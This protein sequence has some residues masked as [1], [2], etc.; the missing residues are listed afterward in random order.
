MVAQLP[1]DGVVADVRVLR[2]T[3]RTL[4]CRYA[5][6]NAL[7]LVIR[8][9]LTLDLVHTFSIVLLTSCL[10]ASIGEA[11]VLRLGISEI[12]H[13]RTSQTVLSLVGE[14][15]PVLA[16]IRSL[17]EI[18]IELCSVFKLSPDALDALLLAQVDLDPGWSGGARAPECAVV[19]INRIFRTEVV[20]VI[21]RGCNLGAECEVLC[22]LHFR[23]QIETFVGWNDLLDGTVCIEFEFI[24]C[25]LTMESTV[26]MRI[27]MAMIY[28][29]VV[30][31]FLE[32]AV[33]SRTMNGSIGIG[34]EDSSVVGVRTERTLGCRRRCA[35]AR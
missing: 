24:D 33:V 21:G 18:L 20:V 22:H 10:S 23:F 7:L 17:D 25:H 6:C 11:D 15:L 31:A 16:V 12:Y 27:V 2:V 13:R 30:V 29:V 3:V 5:R 32:H 26:G 4:H 8:L 14:G 34:L 35:T 9:L 19:V 1:D 28:D